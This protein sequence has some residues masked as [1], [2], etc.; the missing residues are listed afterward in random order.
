MDLDVFAIVT[1]Y[2]S[3]LYLWWMC[4]LMIMNM[5]FYLPNA[6]VR[7]VLLVLWV[8]LCF[9]RYFAEVKKVEKIEEYLMVLLDC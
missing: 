3:R 6:C 8:Y 7:I 2:Y 5:Y 9:I 4:G 1:R